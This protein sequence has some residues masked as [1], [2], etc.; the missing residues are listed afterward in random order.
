M[1]S[2]PKNLIKSTSTVSTILGEKLQA[3]SKVKAAM[4]NPQT[5]KRTLKRKTW[6]KLLVLAVE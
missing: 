3:V 5:K 2:M 1:A 4:P 6:T